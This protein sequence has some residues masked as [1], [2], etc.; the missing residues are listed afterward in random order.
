MSLNIKA[1][2]LNQARTDIKA[3]PRKGISIYVLSWISK[4]KAVRKARF[5]DFGKERN[6]H[7]NM[8]ISRDVD[9]VV[10]KEQES[11]TCHKWLTSP[12]RI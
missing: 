12:E 1:Q 8:S 5:K 11:H 6:V 3:T 10:L 9:N 2:S 4:H 7:L